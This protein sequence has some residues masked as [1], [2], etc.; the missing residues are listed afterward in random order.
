MLIVSSQFRNRDVGATCEADTMSITR[1]PDWAVVDVETSGIDPNTCRVISVAAL[2]VT[3]D[4]TIEHTVVSLLDAGVD[5]GPTNIHGLTRPM[6]DGQP[7]FAAIAPAL[8]ALLRG[9]TLVAHNVAFDYAFLAAEARRAAIELPVNEVMCTVE[10]AARLQLD[11]DNL[12]LATLAHYFGVSQ[13]LPHDAFDDA[14]VLSRILVH[15]LTR[16]RR[17]AVPLPFRHPATLQPPAF[18]PEVPIT[19]SSRPV[20]PNHSTRSLNGARHR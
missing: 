19:S 6:L 7:R 4:G 1:S 9:R 14:A 11:V 15:A 16:A 2:A 12:K 5:P 20:S 13:A 17:L 18:K 3:A 8:T 10:L